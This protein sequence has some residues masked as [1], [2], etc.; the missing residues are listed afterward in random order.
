LINAKR[1]PFADHKNHR[2]PTH[3]TFVGIGGD[4]FDGSSIRN[5]AHFDRCRR[6]P[7][8]RNTAGHDA[9]IALAD[10]FDVEI[11]GRT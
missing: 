5:D 4:A 8:N 3:R 1:L 7:S 11:V 2:G 6:S 9:R 10:I